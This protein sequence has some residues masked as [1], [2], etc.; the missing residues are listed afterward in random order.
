MKKTMM[1]ALAA[2]AITMTPTAAHATDW[3]SSLFGKTSAKQT[4]PKPY[5][6]SSKGYGSPGWGKTPCCTSGSSGGGS[7]SS[8]GGTP[9]PV[10]EPGM[11]GLMGLGLGALAFGRR[12]RRRAL[13]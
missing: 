12:L 8:S 11:I 9:T 3:L 1:L 2:S 10:P 6:Y 5:S 7:S 13:G 4:K